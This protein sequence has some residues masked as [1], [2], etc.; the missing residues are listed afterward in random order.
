MTLTSEILARFTLLVDD[1]S[2]L[3]SVEELD[4][5]QKIYEDIC[6]DRDWEWL[7]KT[8][9]GNTSTSLA[10]IALP[11]DFKKVLPNKD[12]RSVVFVGTDYQ[13]YEI[14]PF[15]SRRDYRNQN[16]FC[17]IDIVNQR[18]YFTLQPTSVKAVEYDYIKTPPALDIVGA[19]PT[20]SNPLFR[21][22]F[23]PVISYGMAASFPAIEQADKGTSYAN[24]NRVDYLR[25]LS[26][27]QMED[28]NI[29]LSI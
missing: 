10:Y 5:A 6:N 27:M 13:E 1:A 24:E 25:I 21:S 9:T 8:A 17:Y 19:T 7:K 14:I 18:L 3:S 20:G 26:D 12:N 2:E 29:K 23:Y 22:G 28:A 4:L 11:S 15:S 16:G